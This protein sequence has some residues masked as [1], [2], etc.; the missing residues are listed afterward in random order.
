MLFDKKSDLNPEMPDGDGNCFEVHANFLIDLSV[1]NPKSLPDYTL[2][3]GVPTGQGPIEGIEFPHCWLEF[4]ESIV[5][6]ISNGNK[7]NMPRASY[8]HLGNINSSRVKRY[9]WDEVKKNILK[10]KHYGPWEKL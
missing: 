1:R 6:D 2:C 9:A 7:V 5:I 8:Y 3:H 10:H 4:K